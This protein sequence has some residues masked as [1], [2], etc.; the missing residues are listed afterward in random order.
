MSPFN[1]ANAHASPITPQKYS[2]LIPFEQITGVILAG[3][4]STRM[5]GDDKGL[6][7]FRG[8]PM[9]MHVLLR[10]APQVGSV[11]I[12]ANQNLDTYHGLGHP[13]ITDL[14]SD[15]GPLGGIHAALKI[16]NTDFLLT[17]PCD[18]PLLPTDLAERL[19]HALQG[20]SADAAVVATG[21]WLQPLFCLMRSS[22]RDPIES[23]LNDS[24][25]K[26][27]GWHAHCNVIHVPFDDQPEAF[28]NINTQDDLKQLES[29]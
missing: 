13:V 23:Y 16:C 21:P 19:G 28:A 10:L 14:I 3:G 24:G 1:A 2:K 15:A 26:A 25:R 8:Y 18:V 11:L 7:P 4:R 9:A 12:S 20:S 17:A 29:E 5:G 27:D 6:M 22:L